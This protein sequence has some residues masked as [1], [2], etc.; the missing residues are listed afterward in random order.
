MKR[1]LLK[2]EKLGTFRTWRVLTNFWSFVCFIFIVYDFFNDNILAD[3]SVL[4]AITGIFAACLAIYSAE[5]EF[6]RWHNMHSSLHPG[7]VY[8]ILW[9]LL[10]LFLVLGSIVL[11]IP[12]HMPIEVSGAYIAVITIL[13]IT[14]ESKNYYKRRKGR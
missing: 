1:L 13:A 6:R 12:Y 3:N 14:R 10:V 9:T 7:E 2:L 5:K 4:L 11:H 8:V